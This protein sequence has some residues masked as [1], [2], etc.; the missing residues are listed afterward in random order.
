M[1]LILVLFVSINITSFAQIYPIVA[2]LNDAT[3]FYNDLNPDGDY[4]APHCS[5]P[6]Y[7]DLDID[8][9][10]SDDFSFS[11]YSSCGSGVVVRYSRITPYGENKIAINRNQISNVH[12][13]YWPDTTYLPVA[14]IFNYGDTINESYVY[15]NDLTV[16]CES[17]FIAYPFTVFDIDDWLNE[18][19]NF[20]GCQITRN[21]TLIHCWIRVDV[22][23]TSHVIMK[24][25]ACVNPNSTNNIFTIDSYSDIGIYPN[26][27]ED[28]FIIENKDE[29]LNDIRVQIVNLQ[30]QVVYQKEIFTNQ[31]TYEISLENI[32]PGLYFV[33]ISDSNKIYK[34]RIIVN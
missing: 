5:G 12:P 29:Y 15:T 2:G 13:E 33:I 22:P 25:Y 14:Q 27:A 21:D 10:G 6:Y 17:Y 4:N 23:S 16:L 7:F 30:G 3:I 20:I 34:Q 19:D 1:K 18:I 32:E 31:N 28:F 8:N 11:V 9:N 24:D 26:P